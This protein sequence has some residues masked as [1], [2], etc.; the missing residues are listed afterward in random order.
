MADKKT[1]KYKPQ[2]IPNYWRE[3]FG[4][5]RNQARRI[6]QGVR[7]SEILD[8]PWPEYKDTVKRLREVM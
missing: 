7:H 8:G 2:G 6:M 1:I 4:C 3:K 5:T